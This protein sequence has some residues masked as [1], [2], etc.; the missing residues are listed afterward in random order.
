MRRVAEALH[1]L[2]GGFVQHGVVR[3]VVDPVLQFFLG[4]Q[5]AE[6]QQVGDFQE[7]AVLGQNFDGIAAIAQDSLVAVNVGDRCSCTTPYS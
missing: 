6:E 7:R 4:G 2:L 5:F 3:D 1:E